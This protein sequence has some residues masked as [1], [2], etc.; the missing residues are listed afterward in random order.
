MGSPGSPNQDGAAAVSIVKTLH[1][2]EQ[3]ATNSSFLSLRDT[4]S[5]TGTTR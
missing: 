4:G 3:S 2:D 1:V 5:R